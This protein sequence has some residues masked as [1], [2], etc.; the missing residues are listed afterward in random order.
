M[1]TL[2]SHFPI[3]PSQRI[4]RPWF[5]APSLRQMLKLWHRR[6]R[7]RAALA[8]FSERELRD[9]GQSPAEAQMECA[10]PFWRA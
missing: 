10:K 3:S 8:G 7:G 1:S 2:T 6:L 9:I 5:V 4:G